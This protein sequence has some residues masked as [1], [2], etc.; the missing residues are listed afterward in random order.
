MKKYFFLVILFVTGAIFADV[1]MNPN[2]NTLWEMTSLKESSWTG[3]GVK[4]VNNNTGFSLSNDNPSNK[5][6]HSIKRMIPVDKSYPYLVFKTTSITPYKGYR[7]WSVSFRELGSSFGSITN[8][9]PG[10]MV[11]NCFENL[12]KQFTK[13]QANMM[14]Y[15]YDFK[16][17]FNYIKMVKKP[18][19]YITATGDFAQKKRIQSGDKVKFTVYLKETAEEV[20]LKLLYKKYLYTIKVNGNEI[21]ELTP[22]DKD[23]KIWSCELPIKSLVST[24]G[25]K[26]KK[27]EILMRATVLGGSIKE[28]I[29]TPLQYS[30][31]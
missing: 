29:W 10:I 18:D 8:A 7:N 2:A 23:Q 24:K 27:G 1:K 20:V 5:A 31:E 25:K 13:K 12:P 17:D 28:P 4:I 11:M 6:P 19:N 16:A 22:E 30:F 15:F 26:F 14:F 21:I 9:E 3:K